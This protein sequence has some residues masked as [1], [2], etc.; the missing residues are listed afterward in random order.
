VTR[1]P[2]RD[3]GGNVDADHPRAYHRRVSEQLDGAGNCTTACGRRINYQQTMSS[4]DDVDCRGCL[5]KMPPGQLALDLDE[6]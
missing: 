5:A 1:D 3:A 4:W 6:F 2:E